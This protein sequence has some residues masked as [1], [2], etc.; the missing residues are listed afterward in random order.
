VDASRA[1]AAIAPAD[2]VLLPCLSPFYRSDFCL[3]DPAA[4]QRCVSLPHTPHPTPFSSVRFASA[5]HTLHPTPY[6]PYPSPLSPSVRFAGPQHT[7]HF[8]PASLPPNLGILDPSSRFSDDS[9]CDL[10]LL[11]AV[12]LLTTTPA[13]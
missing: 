2:L 10:Q 5:Q 8:P 11:D 3:Y 4:L 9:L 1:Y 13:P 6:T 7:L 12:S